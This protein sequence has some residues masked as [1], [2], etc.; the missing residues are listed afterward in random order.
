MI[1]FFHVDFYTPLHTLIIINIDVNHRYRYG[2]QQ[3]IWEL[4]R[5]RSPHQRLRP[6]P[7]RRRLDQR[8]RPRV[9]LRPLKAMAAEWEVAEERLTFPWR[10]LHRTLVLC[11]WTAR[12]LNVVQQLRGRPLQL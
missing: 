2:N 3:A 11:L 7:L 9:Q 4:R 12:D 8:P 1:Q 6:R 5:R 10:R